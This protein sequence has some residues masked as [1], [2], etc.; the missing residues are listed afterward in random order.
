MLPAVDWRIRRVI[1]D[2]LIQH[3]DDARPLNRAAAP[4]VPPDEADFSRE[5]E[6][7]R[8]LIRLVRRIGC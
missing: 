4:A 2:C 5:A 6:A 8:C 7:R 1:E 3:C